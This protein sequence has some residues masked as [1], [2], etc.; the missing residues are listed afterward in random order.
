ML[1]TIEERL[2]NCLKQCFRLP[3]VASRV[4]NGNRKLCF[5]TILIYVRR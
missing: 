3:F 5:Y 4:T 2:K 1:L